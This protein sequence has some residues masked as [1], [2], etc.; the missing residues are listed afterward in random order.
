MTGSLVQIEVHMTAAHESDQEHME[1]VMQVW[2]LEL[3]KRALH[4]VE[5]GSE[6]SP[7]QDSDIKLS[8]SSRSTPTMSED[9]TSFSP[10]RE[11]TPEIVP[12]SNDNN[13]AGTA[14]LSELENTETISI[15]MSV[16][17]MTL[18]TILKG[19]GEGSKGKK[20]LDIRERK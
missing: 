16:K 18:N 1:G 14:H 4:M 13:S 11:G 8:T 12:E 5:G 10:Q 20:M 17:G 7:S 9:S 6:H 15:E 3:V 2:V 19:R